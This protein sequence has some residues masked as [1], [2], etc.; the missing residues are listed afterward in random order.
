M[1]NIIK[2]LYTR[3][4]KHKLQEYFQYKNIHEIPKLSKITLNRGLGDD[5]NNAKLLGS[6]IQ[7]LMLISGQK[8]CIT[9][10]KKSIAGFKLREK[11]AVGLTVNLRDK[12][13]YSFLEKLI[14]LVLPNIRDFRGISQ[15]HFDGHG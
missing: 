8:P 14:H 11:M 5:A 15:K 6:S 9:R 7:E 3:Q 2:N 12:K 4:V 10:A 1:A 13:M